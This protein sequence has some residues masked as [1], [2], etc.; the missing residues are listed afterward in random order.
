MRRGP[1]QLD[2]VLDLLEAGLPRSRVLLLLALG[3]VIVS[4]LLLD[5]QSLIQE[6]TNLSVGWFL[7]VVFLLY[8]VRPLLA[9]PASLLAVLVGFRFGLFV[10]LVIAEVGFVISSTLVFTAGRYTVADGRV[11]G[12]VAESAEQ[13]V[14]HTGEFR[15]VFSATLLPSPPDPVSYAS[16]LSGVPLS[17]FAL[18]TLAGG[19]PWMALYVSLGHSMSSLR[20]DNIRVGRQFLVVVTLLA[21]LTV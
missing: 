10:G 20:L 19:L 8:I 2:R 21:V 18:G 16:G 15:G 1:K 7:V 6:L 3:I 11:L 9:V 12:P 14:D 5:P 13:F 4:A 17:Q